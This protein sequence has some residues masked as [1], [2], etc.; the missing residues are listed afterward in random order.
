MDAAHTY[1]GKAKPS[2]K[3]KMKNTGQAL[4]TELRR[5]SRSLTRDKRKVGFARETKTVT[6]NRSDEA[7]MVTYN[8]GSDGNYVSEADRTKVGLP[9]LRISTKR[10]TV[11][12]AGASKGKYFTRLPF[13][14]LSPNAAQADTF[15]YF[16]TSLISV[17][18]TLDDGNVSVFTKEGVKV[19]NEE[20]VLITCKS[21]P[22]LVGKRYER[23]RYCTP[24]I[25]QKGQW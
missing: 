22:I 6:F 9:I 11:A 13:K 15:E 4:G 23:G 3:Q 12:H 5:F 10:V 1:K 19:Y 7:V 2:L 16:P 21:K 24:L 25:H 18:K 17:G 8:S 14:W 20:D